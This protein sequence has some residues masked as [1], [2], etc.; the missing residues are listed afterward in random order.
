MAQN[1]LVTVKCYV[2][3][4]FEVYFIVNLYDNKVMDLNQHPRKRGTYEAS[5]DLNEADALINALSTR[6]LTGL[7]GARLVFKSAFARSL[8][9]DRVT[10]QMPTR[11]WNEAADILGRMAAAQRGLEP[12]SFNFV[13]PDTQEAAA[14]S[15]RDQLS[16]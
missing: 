12:G 7:H 11:R 10:L 6:P 2:F 13:S 15:I 16:E 1:T 14:T 3:I 5:M 9:R 8:D 4:L